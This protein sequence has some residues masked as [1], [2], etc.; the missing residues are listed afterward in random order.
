VRA[1]FIT[2]NRAAL[3]S[4]FQQLVCFTNSLPVRF[5]EARPTVIGLGKEIFPEISILGFSQPHRSPASQ[6]NP[7]HK[8]ASE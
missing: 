7:N 4:S 1:S 6:S 2:T 8:P 5:W 3:Q